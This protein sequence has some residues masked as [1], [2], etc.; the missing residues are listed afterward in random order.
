[1]TKM[2]HAKKSQARVA[3][4]DNRANDLHHCACS[5][6]KLSPLSRSTFS[7]NDIQVLTS[8][9]AAASSIFSAAIFTI[10]PRKDENL[11]SLSKMATLFASAILAF[12]P[13]RSSTHLDYG[14][15]SICMFAAVGITYINRFFEGQRRS[16]NTILVYQLLLVLI[17]RSRDVHT[18][19][20]TSQHATATVLHFLTGQIYK[21]RS[22]WFW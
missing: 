22:V 10:F 2:K 18:A 4:L 5:T 19:S 15:V 14:L 3:Y 17:M 6:I 7:T 13:S 20:L 9:T 21:D 11:S 8:E 1:M 16:N 12:A